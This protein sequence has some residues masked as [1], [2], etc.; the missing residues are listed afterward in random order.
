MNL[1]SQVLQ[2]VLTAVIPV[3]VVW[4]IYQIRDLTKKLYERIEDENPSIAYLLRTFAAD[5]VRAA[6]QIYG[7]GKGEQKFDYALKSIEGLLALYGLKIDSSVIGT[8]I[9][10]AVY[11]EFHWDKEKKKD[12]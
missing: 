11:N 9:E 6:E 5:A 10:T 12:E 7:G 3:V 4:F 1:L 2:A 8:A